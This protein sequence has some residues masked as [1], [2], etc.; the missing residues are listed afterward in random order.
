MRYLVEALD[1][2]ER[3]SITDSV[4]N[5]IPKATERFE[6]TE[7]RL[8]VLLGDNNHN[9]EFVKIVRKVQKDEKQKAIKPKD[10]VEVKSDR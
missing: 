2:Y 9:K 6:V 10:K 3:Y 7:E 5:R 1:T 4:L 8:K